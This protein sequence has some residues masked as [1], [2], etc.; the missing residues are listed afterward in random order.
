MSK[1]IDSPCKDCRDRTLGCHG[2]CKKY[3][4]WKEKL[5]EYNKRK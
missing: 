1:I 5:E 2:N 4:L 3:K